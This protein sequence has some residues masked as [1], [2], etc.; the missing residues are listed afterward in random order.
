MDAGIS[1]LAE[2]R[3][4]ASGTQGEELPPDLRAPAPR[5]LTDAFAESRVA[6]LRSRALWGCLAAGAHCVSMAPLPIV[7]T[8]SLYLLPLAYL[9]WIGMCLGAIGVVAYA[10]APAYRRAR[11][12]LTEGH[13]GFALVVSLAKTCIATVNGQPSVYALRATL[14]LNPDIEPPL[15]VEV[16]SPQF[17][18]HHKD[19][20]STRF[21]VGDRVPILWF[22][23]ELEKTVQILDFLEA[24]PQCELIRGRR[25]ADR[26]LWKVIANVVAV[27]AFLL[28]LMWSLYAL[29]RYRPLDFGFRQAVLPSTVFGTLGLLAFAA[30]GVVEL[31][32]RRR[33][34]ERNVQALASGEAVETL[35]PMGR[36]KLIGGGLLMLTGGALLGGIIG[37]CLAF[38]ANAWLDSSPPKQVPVTITEMLQTTHNFVFRTYTMK[39]RRVG[40]Q[41][42]DSILSTPDHIDQFAL[43]LGVA[44]VR[45][46]RFGWPWVETI[47]PMGRAIR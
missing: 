10:V 9:P 37:M 34:G 23:G 36:F 38:T 25:A 2:S 40:A 21:R 16:Q 43:P 46:G 47:E 32:N 12:Y 27:A 28:A 44:L 18:T 45:Q 3:V 24:M 42:D 5:P 4:A 13:T 14:N 22:P 8:L 41:E 11:R 39:F 19:A 30:V 6:R 17:P 33:I 29:E 35:L 20:V 7:K 31:R 26:P 15:L 1:P